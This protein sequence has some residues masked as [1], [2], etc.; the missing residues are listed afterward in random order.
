MGELRYPRSE[1]P[2]NGDMNQ[3]YRTADSYA[4]FYNVQR[5]PDAVSPRLSPQKPVV[6]QSRKGHMPL[7]T[8]RPKLR[9]PEEPMRAP[10]ASPRIPTISG[11]KENPSFDDEGL[12]SPRRMLG[13]LDAFSS[14]V[15]AGSGWGSA[16]VHALQGHK[17]TE[18]QAA[19]CI[20][21]HWRR[22][23]AVVNQI[24]EQLAAEHIQRVQRERVWLREGAAAALQAAMRGKTDRVA[25]R[26]ARA[27]TKINMTW[28]GHL[29]R[30]HAKEL[31]GARPGP[32]PLASLKRSLSFTSKKRGGRAKETPRESSPAPPTPELPMPAPT[33]PKVSL[34]K[35][36]VRSMSF[37]RKG[38]SSSSAAVASGSSSKPPEAPNVRSTRRTFVLE[39]GPTGLGLE[40][41]ATNTVVTVKEGGRAE[42]QGLMMVGDTVLT[43]DGKSCAGK[44]MQQVMVPGRP[45]YVVEISRPERGAL[46]PPKPLGV[47]RR[48]L[49]FDRKQPMRRSFS[50]E[51]K[52]KSAE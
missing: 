51:R 9:L 15:S 20:Q 49:S 47:V 25:V 46:P 22:H 43:I 18:E 1:R 41:D 37:D 44:L 4:N 13:S 23:E 8:E 26:E 36:V 27:A 45:V 32:G 10:S 34:A 30:V 33:A 11:D 28:R 35:R 16:L 5:S 24:A 17:M 7:V 6:P 3:A 21:A 38:S 14:M 12:L 29:A 40:L 19:L 50:F 42:R 48:S 52:K 31:R 39:R 2:P